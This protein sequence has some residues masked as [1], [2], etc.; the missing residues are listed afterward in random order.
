M[1]QIWV[2]CL[3]LFV[4]CG[5]NRLLKGDEALNKG[6]YD[7]AEKEFTDVLNA[8]D[9]SN[10]DR[11]AAMGRISQIE[12]AKGQKEYEAKKY[13]EAIACLEKSAE[14]ADKAG[15][16]H[17]EGLDEKVLD[18][19][20][21]LGEKEFAANNAS[22]AKKYY[23]ALVKKPGCEKF[24]KYSDIL[25]R[26]FTIS[27]G[28]NGE[29][30]A[31]AYLRDLRKA[32]PKYVFDAKANDAFG[33]ILSK[34]TKDADA[35][36]KK[37]N[38]DGAAQ[39][40]D[41][42]SVLP[43]FD[44][45]KQKQFKARI[46]FIQGKDL[47]LE[48]KVDDGLAKFTRAK[49]IDLNIGAE[50]GNFVNA[51]FVRSAKDFQRK[52]QYKEAVDKLLVAQRIAPDNRDI[53]TSL[54]PDAYY[55]YANSLFNAKDYKG[56]LT[57]MKA[58]LAL[59]KDHKNL[60]YLWTRWEQTANAVKIATSKE[61]PPIAAFVDEQFRNAVAIDMVLGQYKNRRIKWQ[62]KVTG[63][64][65]VGGKACGKFL[66]DSTVVYGLPTAS[67]DAQRFASGCE[68]AKD[69]Q[70]AVIEGTIGYV[71]ELLGIRYIVLNVTSV[72]FVE[73]LE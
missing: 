13:Q 63:T 25:Y 30:A 29:D 72:K 10:D 17:I 39:I 70:E 60:K 46:V 59:S 6:Q 58:G 51:D 43:N 19:Y 36:F 4:A 44:E 49:E 42:A 32:D 34:L 20:F 67:L 3:C 33:R 47:I 16:S 14:F 64:D 28:E 38:Y 73:P 48:G 68:E 15:Y 52:R 56:T 57:A 22:G 45:F 26:L 71:E 8:K 66:F 27:L 21:Q 9:A 37:K 62:F 65:S 23:A 41:K 35:E 2:L 24:P 50:I 1:K 18:S 55:D 53:S 61:F 40:V 69:K 12:Y 31:L 54:L 7:Q 11:N 5:G